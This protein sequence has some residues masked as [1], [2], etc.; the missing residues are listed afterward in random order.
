MNPKDRAAL[1]RVP[2]HLL[3]KT[4]MV[5]A[6]MACRLGAMKYGPMNWREKPISLTGYIGAIYRHLIALENGQDHDVESGLSHFAH[7]IA[8]ASIILDA[9]LHDMLIDDRVCPS[10]KNAVRLDLLR[11]ANEIGILPNELEMWYS[12]PLHSNPDSGCWEWG[13][14]KNAGGYGVMYINGTCHQAHRISWRI[15]GGD[16]PDGHVV[17]HKCDNPG[18]VN[19]EHLETGTHAENS[20]DM[21]RRGRST[22]GRSGVPLEKQIEIAKRRLSGERGVDLAEEYGIT[23]QQVSG[24]KR[25]WEKKGREVYEETNSRGDGSRKKDK[26]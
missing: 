8:T 7:I 22:R 4:G 14:T 13:G 9:Q 25:W 12:T 2:M 23:A 20:M 21:V 26:S 5:E 18:C 19:P 24:F 1:N 15:H 16:I 17:R 6:A 10:D 11:A 3:P